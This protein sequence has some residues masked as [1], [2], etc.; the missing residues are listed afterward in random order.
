MKIWYT[1]NM[2]Y[3]STLKKIFFK[4]QENEWMD[5][6]IIL[7]YHYLFTY[8]YSRIY[9]TEFTQSQKKNLF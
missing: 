4:L 8:H 1:W 2:E 9:N 7:N 3:Y 6:S 5:L